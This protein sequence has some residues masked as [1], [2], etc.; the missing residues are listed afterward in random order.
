ML[1]RILALSVANLP[2]P[3]LSLSMAQPNRKGKYLDVGSEK[4]F[5]NYKE[6]ALEQVRALKIAELQRKREEANIVRFEEYQHLLQSQ[7]TAVIYTAVILV[8][9]GVLIVLSF[10]PAYWAFWPTEFFTTFGTFLLAPVALQYIAN[11]VLDAYE[12]VWLGLANVVFAIACLLLVALE[13]AS[14]VYAFA[15]GFVTSPTLVEQVALIIL[16]VFTIVL[17][18]L[19]LFA[20]FSG[21]GIYK[22]LEKRFERTSKN[23]KTP[24][25]TPARHI[26][27]ETAPPFVDA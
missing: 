17:G 1:S 10:W 4:V 15:F 5:V 27:L 18:V 9:C 23:S 3:S 24:K 11:L 12:N 19:Q 2:P 13:I 22:G 8:I 16:L 25:P 14:C 6:L 21:W 20:T 26:E 7:R